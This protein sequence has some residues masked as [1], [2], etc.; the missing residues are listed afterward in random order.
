[1]F[2]NNSKKTTYVIVA[3]LPFVS[4]QIET[5]F[6]NRAKQYSVNTSIEIQSE[7]EIIWKYLIEVPEIHSEEYNYGF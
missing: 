1:L 3:L 6:S 5:K 2:R 7:P 4:G